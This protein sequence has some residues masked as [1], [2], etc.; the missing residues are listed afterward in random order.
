MDFTTCTPYILHNIRCAILSVVR[1]IVY[2]GLFVACQ[3][4]TF[5]NAFVCEHF[6]M[7]IHWTRSST[8][9]TVKMTDITVLDRNYL[10]P[11]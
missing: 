8:C 11:I 1:V 10:C 3:F 2:I 5:V 9:A 6:I 4:T 7:Q